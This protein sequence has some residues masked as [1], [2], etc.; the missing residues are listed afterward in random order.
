[1]QPSLIKH[2]V[3][4]VHLLQPALQARQVQVVFGVT[5]RLLSSVISLLFSFILKKSALQVSQPA[6]KASVAMWVVAQ[7]VAPEGG[8]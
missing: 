1:L 5:W 4:S 6:F 2:V 7:L 3:A 8:G